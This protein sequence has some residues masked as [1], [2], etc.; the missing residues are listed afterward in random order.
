[1]WSQEDEKTLYELVEDNKTLEEM[2]Q[3]LRKTVSS[4]R[5]KLY[6][7]DLDYGRA[8]DYFW[9]EDDIIYLEY[10][11]QDKNVDLEEVARFLGRSIVSVKSK[12]YDLRKNGEGSYIKRPWTEKEDNYLRRY[13][14]THE[15]KV[16]AKS[17]NRTVPALH[18]RAKALGIQYKHSDFYPL[19]H[20]KMVKLGKEGKTAKEIAEILKLNRRSVEDYLQR[21]KLEYKHGDKQSAFREIINK[22]YKLHMA[23]KERR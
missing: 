15:I 14:Q 2:S 1:M 8:N 9:S 22:E 5:A 17:L 4:V 16:L 18:H 13:Y 3:V 7:L 21:H 20:E 23:K 11:S 19:Y 6:R 10:A 12:L